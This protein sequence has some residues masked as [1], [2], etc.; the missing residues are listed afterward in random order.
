PNFREFLSDSSFGHDGF[1]GRV[2]F[3]DSKHQIG[4]AFTTNRLV[5][6]ENPHKYWDLIVAE[7]QRILGEK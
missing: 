4:F 2:G 5:Q 7:L 3:A 1:G 6:G